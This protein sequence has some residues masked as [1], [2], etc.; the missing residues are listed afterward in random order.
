MLRSSFSLIVRWS[1]CA[2]FPLNTQLTVV[3]SH[4]VLLNCFGI[5]IYFR[6]IYF[7]FICLFHIIF[8][9]VFIFFCFCPFLSSFCCCRF[10]FVFYSP[11]FVLLDLPHFLLS[12]HSIS[13]SFFLFFFLF[14]NQGRSLFYSSFSAS[15]SFILLFEKSLCVSLLEPGNKK[16][17]KST[18]Y[19]CTK[20]YVSLILP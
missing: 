16:I 18:I 1:F 19:G 9:F 12:T 10:G 11:I 13:S 3:G 8:L 14:S 2:S 20:T 15:V 7:V 4:G 17:V 6:V 5:V